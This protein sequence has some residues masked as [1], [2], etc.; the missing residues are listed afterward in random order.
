MKAITEEA[1]LSVGYEGMTPHLRSRCP[2][3]YR[4]SERGRFQALI[5]A[6]SSFPL[7]RDSVFILTART[8]EPD[9]SVTD[10]PSFT[11]HYTSRFSMRSQWSSSPDS[12]TLIPIHR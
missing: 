7:Y 4:R 9:V 5:P 1:Y 3:K 11:H 2:Y 8:V 6:P 12:T 10:S